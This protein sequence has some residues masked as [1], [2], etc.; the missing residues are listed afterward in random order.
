MADLVVRP[1]EV[2][3]RDSAH[4]LL[5]A[6]LIEHHL[7]ADAAGIMFTANPLTGARDKVM[8]NAAWG[9]GEAIVGGHVTPDTFLLDKQ[10]GAVGSEEIADKAVPV[11]ESPRLPMNMTSTS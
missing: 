10:T 11:T 3:D 5:T 7:P 6:Q 2:A 1:A 8:I 4:R 9:L